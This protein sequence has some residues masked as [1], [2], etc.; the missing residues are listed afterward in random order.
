MKKV[1][2]FIMFLTT[3]LLLCAGEY[4]SMYI[5]NNSNDQGYMVR[6]SL[7]FKG[8]AAL[9]DIALDCAGTK[10]G[11]IQRRI[12]SIDDIGNG[13]GCCMVDVANSNSISLWVKADI[14][15]LS[16]TPVHSQV[17]IVEASQATTPY[18]AEMGISGNSSSQ[19]LSTSWSTITNYSNTNANIAGW[20]YASDVLTDATGTSGDYLAI[21]SVSFSGATAADYEFGISKED[22]APYDGSNDTEIVLKRTIA[23]GTEDDLGNG[24]ACGI[25]NLSNG[26][27]LRIKGTI[28]GSYDVTIPESNITLVKLDGTNTTPYACMKI[29]N[30]STALTLTQNTWI[31][32]SHFSDGLRDASYWEFSGTNDQLTPINLSAGYYLLNFFVSIAVPNAE[33]NTAYNVKIAIFNNGSQIADATIVRQL[34]K[35]T[36]SVRDIGAASGTA[37]IAVDNPNVALDMRLYQNDLSDPT[38]IVTYS[39]VGLFRIATINDGILPVTLSSF[40]AQYLNNNAILCWTTQS[41]T[42]NLGW[43]VYR[44]E[45]EEF[46]E[47]IQINTDLILGAGITTEPTEYTFIDEYEVESGETYWYWLESRE[48]SGIIEIYGPISLTIPLNEEDPDL[49]D[50]PERYG[51]FQNYP[52]PFNP[53][54]IINFNLKED[55]PVTIKIYNMR[56]ELIR[57][58]VDDYRKAGCYSEVWDMRNEEG[59][60]V[61]SGIYFYKMKAGKYTSLKKMML[62]K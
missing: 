5:T 48:I 54:T 39:S 6:F 23:S 18:Y 50:I 46:E 56:G 38:T 55:T 45:T 2:L 16:F 36:G 59:K 27:N 58:L 7:S 47:A 28:S 3:P 33:A 20:T 24:C 44:S 43:N 35:K 57:V 31:V 60:L 49:P 30:N 61:S 1:I 29:N 37:I 17:V 32:E 13:A 42:N 21:L 15:P 62:V 4:A 25:V 12:S 19:T 8:A 22:D 14:D 40:T 51:L 41:E 52:N 10:Y 11:I 26:D 53:D 34:Q 9:W